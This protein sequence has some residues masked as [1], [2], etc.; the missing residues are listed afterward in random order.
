MATELEYIEQLKSEFK[1]VGVPVLAK[2][3]PHDIE[4][5]ASMNQIAYLVPVADE[6]SDADGKVVEAKTI[7]HVYYV[8]SKGT[9]SE[10]VAPEKAVSYSTMFPPAPKLNSFQQEADSWYTENRS[11]NVVKFDVVESNPQIETCKYRSFVVD[12]ELATEKTVLVYREN[13][14]FNKADM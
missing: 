14:V 5:R 11:A 8:Y 12:G 6:K 9:T 4:R 1:H 13:G 2:N 7:G 3:D 10:Y